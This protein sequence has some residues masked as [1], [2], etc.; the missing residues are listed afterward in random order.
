L[1]E[2]DF[3]APTLLLIGNETWGLSKAAQ[4]LCD[5]MTRIPMHGSASSLNMACAASIMLYEINRQRP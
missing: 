1:N 5:T 2:H 3:T 4:A